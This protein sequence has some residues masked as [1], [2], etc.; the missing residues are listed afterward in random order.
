MRLKK[1]QAFVTE[2]F[3]EPRPDLRTAQRWPGA[4]K[5]GKLWYMDLD[6][7]ESGSNAETLLDQLLEDPDVARLVG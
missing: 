3:A 7:W 1:L 5:V 6:R 2:Y 4:R